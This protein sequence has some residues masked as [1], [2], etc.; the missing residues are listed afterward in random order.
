MHDFSVD[1]AL[2]DLAS[3]HYDNTEYIRNYG[4]FKAEVQKFHS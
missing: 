4:E 2:L 3:E 1:S